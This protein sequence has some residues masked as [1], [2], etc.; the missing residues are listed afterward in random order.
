MT[1]SEAAHG[2]QT[3]KATQKQGFYL[4]ERYER[5]DGVVYLTGIQALVRMLLDRARQDRRTGLNTATFVSGYEGSPLAGYD[6]ELMK[7]K[8]LLDNWSISL[9]P[10]LNEEYGATAVMGSQLA[11]HVGTMSDIDGVTGIWYGKAPGLDRAADALRH[12]NMMGTGPNGGAVAI[13]GDDPG[14]KSSTIASA[15][16]AMLADLN[17]PTLYPAD[18]QEVVE[19][20]IHAQYLSRFSGT[21]AAL[22]IVTAVADGASTVHVHPHMSA[23]IMGHAKPSNHTPSGV[24]LGKTLV[25]LERSLHETR[26]P[27]ALEYARNNG[28]NTITRSGADD[29]IGIVT[30]GKTYLDL[31]SA[32][33][34]LGLDDTAMKQ[35]GI[36]L[37]K[38]GMVWPLEPRI[39]ERFADGLEEIIVI[40]EKHDF[41]E[42]AVRNVLYGRRNPPRIVGRRAA[43]GSVLFPVTGE[44]DI[45][46]VTKGLAKA[47]SPRG[48]DTV[49]SW[50]HRPRT[51]RLSLPLAVRSPY[52][53]SGCP[54]NSSTKVN[55]GT[56]VGGGIGCHAMVLIMDEKQVG[57]VMG[58]TQMGGEGVQWI[59]MAPYLKERHIVQNLGDGTF[60]HSGS[61]AIRAA[62]AAKVNITYKL[63]ANSA[64]AMTGGQQPVG[65]M[66]VEQ[67]AQILHDE[68]VRKIIIT[69]E[70][71]SRLRR[72]ALPK[73]VE[74]RDRDELLQVQKELAQIPGV[75]VLIHDQECAAQKR[76]KRKR[77]KLATPTTKVMINE[78]IC[79]G[80]GDCG[81]K[82]NCL[83]VQ[84]VDTE[85][86]RKTR[87]NQSSCNLDYSCLQGDCPSFM[88]V[89]PGGKKDH[90]DPAPLSLDDLPD[91][92][93]VSGRDEFDMR[94]M[95][96]GGTGVVTV[97]QVLAMASVIDGHA[98]RTLDQTGLAQKGGAVV[99]D[100]KMTDNTEQLSAKVGE[101][102]CDLYLGCDALV[103]TDPGNL[104][105]ANPQKTI[106]VV[107]TAHVATGAMVT[108]TDVSYPDDGAI[109]AAIDEVTKKVHYL[110]AADIAHRLFGDEQYANMI[111]VG[112][113]IQTGVLPLSESAIEQAIVLNG[114][115]VE[116]NI[117]ALRRG[118][119]SVADPEALGKI[120]VPEKTTP[121]ISAR[122]RAFGELIGLPASSDAIDLRI[123]ELIAYQDEK[124]ALRYVSALVDT[125]RAEN[126][127]KPGSTEVTEAVAWG[128]HKL[129]AYKD[130][131]EVARL[132]LD[133]RVAQ[134]VKDAFGPDAKVSHK[135]HPPALRALG[136]KK[137]IT[138]GSWFDPAFRGLR[139]M[140]RVRGT[141]LDPF[142]HTTMRQTER[143]LIGEYIDAMR[144]ISATLSESNIPGAVETAKLPDMVRGY[145]DIKL[146]NIDKYRAELTKRL[147]AWT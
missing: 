82:S 138:L 106:A 93:Y 78:R 88:T 73:G 37:L 121:A 81:E 39:V 128:L 111:L 60:L 98:V 34:T 101:G 114:V 31:R 107:S 115:A 108:S 123:D 65:D 48:I 83:S 15:S 30:S 131:Y 35:Y 9:Q 126:E 63:L 57:N 136:M 125:Y 13:V 40:E 28:L 77:G 50:M 29:T 104:T 141:K 4:D 49:R 1:T 62:I 44:L 24:V 18:S 45:D 103:A 32:L 71:P 7:Q 46:S 130:E 8:R 134:D 69:S 109:H 12:A 96:I 119:Q 113:A 94:I 124:Y 72:A 20:G 14:A 67:M 41:L 64:V 142:G 146:R 68:G 122:A 36:R 43:D 56:L 112:A 59:G 74:V 27:R 118:R 54:H 85:F 42:T 87:I 117:Q 53:C 22:K 89:E 127:A 135:L 86:G 91:P 105:V 129:M 102:A 38:L 97:S 140:K 84:P 120:L 21:W 66:P 25:A 145:E 143:Q 100:I 52:F 47:L 61:L 16:E 110:N 55:E 23:P 90:H 6:L 3:H 70:N 75:T 51:H 95:G 2:S 137:K 80:C 17:I 5:E 11:G 132:A 116:R 147:S 79:E 26:L 99:A 58:T 139:S 19:Y 92:Q 10:G 133:P 33:R 76:R 144:T